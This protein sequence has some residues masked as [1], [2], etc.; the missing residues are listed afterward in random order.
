MALA[1]VNT[2]L[3]DVLMFSVNPC[4]DLQ[5]ASEDVEELWAE[6]SYARELVN[7]DPARQTLYETCQRLGVAVTVMTPR[8]PPSRF[9]SRA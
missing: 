4:Y 1:A 8:I 3:I 7:M 5:P 2:G 9:S 6:K